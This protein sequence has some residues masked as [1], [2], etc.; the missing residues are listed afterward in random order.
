MFEI[1]F[2][3]EAMDDLRSFRNFERRRIIAGIEEQLS[4]Q[5]IEQTRNRKRLRSNP[6]A[7]WELRVDDFRVFYDPDL[8]PDAVKIVAVARKQGNKLYIRGQ[9]FEL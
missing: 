8:T 2:T 4:H 9:E 3:P 1:R 7:E 5:P 6:L